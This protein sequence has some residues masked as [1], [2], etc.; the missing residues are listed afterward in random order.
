MKGAGR[1][2]GQSPRLHNP[3]YRTAL[4][5]RRAELKALEDSVTEALWRTWQEKRIGIRDAQTGPSDGL[6]IQTA[7]APSVRKTMSTESEIAA[8][9]RPQ[10]E[11]AHK[12]P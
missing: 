11:E 10:I 5:R 9:D 1:L 4:T 2:R 12:C 8:E 3:D 7:T 6:R